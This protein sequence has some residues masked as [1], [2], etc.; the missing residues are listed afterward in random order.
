MREAGW[1]GEPHLQLQ[2]NTLYLLQ[3]GTPPGLMREA[4]GCVRR[5]GVVSTLQLQYNTLYLL[6]GGTPPG[7]MREVL[8][9]VR[10]G[11][12]ASPASYNYNTGPCIFTGQDSPRVNEGGPGGGGVASPTY[13]HNTRVDEGGPWVCEA[14]GVTSPA[15][16]YNTIIYLYRAGLPQG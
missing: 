6:Q 15:S 12:V 7:L 11:G 13:N 16:N 3:G 2:Y 10:W 4:L 9:C 5:G 14:G 8:G 1:S